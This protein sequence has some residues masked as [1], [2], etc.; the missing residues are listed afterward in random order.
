MAEPDVLIVGAGLA[1][2]CCALRLYEIGVPFRIVE[3]SDGVGGRVRTDD[4]D[5]FRLDRGFQVLLTAYP[6]SERVLDYGPL[7][8]KPF[9][10]GALVRYRGAFHRLADPRRRPLA[11]LRS[12]FGP[13][14]TPADKFRI[15]SLLAKVSAGKIEDQFRRPEGLTLDFLRWGG[16]F[17]DAMIDRFFRPFLGGIFLERDLVTSSRLFRFVFRTFAAGTAAVPNRGM[18]AIPEQLAARLPAESIRLN[19]PVERVEPGRV[20]LRGGEELR[21]K[22]VVVAT[23]GPVAAELL[24]GRLKAPGTRAVCCLYFAADE[25]PLKEPILVLNADD[26]GP[27]NNL[28]VMSDVAPGYTPPG[29]ALVSASV[30]GDPAQDDATLEAA[31]REQLAGWFGPAA[32]GWRPLRT[33]RIRHALPDQ[34][35]PALD[36]PERPVKLAD[37][38]YV[39]GDHRDTASLNGAM[40]S[41][42]RAAQAVAED[43]LAAAAKESG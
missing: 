1:G 39:C 11:G 4:L 34:T 22:A 10:P 20:V 17:S 6:E 41:G 3:A 9:Y 42:W 32:R 43:R 30:L 24:G 14:G 15:F 5:G 12:F 26:P 18:G 7:D 25:S 19:A 38:L 16:R 33:Y 21:A 27:V 35:A 40:A 23:D 36:V 2:L 31:V 29:S 37:G 13:I 28:A 8:L